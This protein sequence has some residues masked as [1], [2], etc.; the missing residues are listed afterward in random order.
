MRGAGGQKAGA[1][2]RSDVSAQTEAGSLLT[3]QGESARDERSAGNVWGRRLVWALGVAAVA[4]FFLV[5]KMYAI[6]PYAGDEH[7]YMFQ[8][9]LVSEGATPYSEFAMAHPPLQSL[10]TAGLLKLAG[11]RFELARLL[12]VLWCLAGGLLLAVIVWREKGVAASVAAMALYVLAY[13]PLRASSHYTGVNMTIALLL[14]ALLAQRLDRLR[15][16]AALCVAAVFTRLYA[17]PGV[18]A[19]TLWTLLADRRRGARLVAW[20]AGIGAAAF[21]ATG[22]WTGFGEMLHNMV[23][24]HA[25]KT[26]MKSASLDNMKSS[27]L[28]HNA[29]P[30]ALF[31]LS[32]PAMV[33]ELARA[34]DRLSDGGGIL[35]R[36][37]RAVVESGIGLE[38]L[39]AA[40]CFSFLL[41]LLNMERVWMYY[42]VPAFPFAAIGGGW[43]V[44]RWIGI[45]AALI[46]AR[47]RPSRAG[48]ERRVL[49]GWTAL[50]FA[51]VVAF[52]TS[53]RLESRLR[54][55]EREMSK[56]PAERVHRYTWRPGALPDCLDEL[57]HRW[58][59][60]DER[61]IGEPYWS[62][63][64][65]LWHESRVLD[66][67]DEVVEEIE[68]RSE[69]GDRIFG[70]S[71]TV[72]LFALLSG[73]GIAGDEVDTNIQR[74]RSGNAD[75]EELVRR[76]DR[77]DTRLIVLRHRFG[78]SGVREV[79]ELVDRRYR[80][81]ETF[82]SA[83]GR[84]FR[85][86]ERRDEPA[87]VER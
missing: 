3:E 4:G 61:V 9:R 23:A 77:P 86:F 74:Y 19:L 30:I 18:A 28:F 75:P 52:F 81:V 55:W 13:E 87:G 84:V 33:A 11:Y 45:A 17:A 29:V 58:I 60:R 47:G 71:G 5:L 56:P 21:V 51:F 25:Q 6:Q 72:P 59:W 15:L 67:A 32:L 26:P 85:M 10:L 50:F 35:N 62:F 12:P 22:L 20:G 63:T 37:R 1:G 53:P 43:L 14:G 54:Y 24:Y 42:F 36:L 65:L 34:Y 2:S 49:L 41:I 16:C 68:K 79:R 69:P 82:E 83:Q 27:V 80:P 46:R 78:V 64:Y 66:I 38:L 7:I 31:A 48:V 57:I 8:A 70:D 76:I 44:S 40:T 39:G 73:R